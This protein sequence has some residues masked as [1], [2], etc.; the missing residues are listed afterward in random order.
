MIE[1]QWSTSLKANYALN[2]DEKKKIEKSKYYSWQIKNFKLQTQET[3]Y[4]SKKKKI[5]A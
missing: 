1:A 3:K 2:K 5:S 4:C